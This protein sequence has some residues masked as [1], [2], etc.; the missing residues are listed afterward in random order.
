MKKRITGKCRAVF[1]KLLR[2][3]FFKAFSDPNRLSLLVHL[4]SCGPTVNVSEL[5]SCCKVHISVISRH[6]A[7]LRQAG[8]ISR[9]KKG[10]EVVYHVNYGKLVAALRELADA[11]EE[12]CGKD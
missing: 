3:D 5:Q 7:V 6:L 8:I 2:P 11:F 9:E 12:C 4:A 1:G 10:R